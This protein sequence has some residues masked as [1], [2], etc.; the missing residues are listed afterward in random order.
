MWAARDSLP[1]SLPLS[2][3]WRTAFSIASCELTPTVFRNLRVL[4]FSASSSMIP[5]VRLHLAAKHPVRPYGVTK[6][7]RQQEY[8]PDH[9]EGLRFGRRGRLPQVECVGH[10]H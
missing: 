10:H 1:F 9:K 6:N 3:A 7:D 4:M 2:I 5:P 8:R